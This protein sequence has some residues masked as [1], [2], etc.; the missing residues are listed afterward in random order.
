VFPVGSFDHN[1]GICKV[2]ET[3]YEYTEFIIKGDEIKKKQLKKY[4]A[5]KWRVKTR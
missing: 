1:R 2:K 5:F 4:T 3:Q